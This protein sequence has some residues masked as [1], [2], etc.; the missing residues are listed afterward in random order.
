MS[1]E[2]MEN[3]LNALQKA[4]PFIDKAKELCQNFFTDMQSVDENVRR[5]FDEAQYQEGYS[6][7]K[8]ALSDSLKETIPAGAILE[9]N[10][11][12][13]IK[14][15][16]PRMYKDAEGVFYIHFDKRSTKKEVATNAVLWKKALLDGY[17]QS[18]EIVQISGNGN[19]Y[20]IK[21]GQLVR[22]I[23]IISKLN[24]EL[25]PEENNIGVEEE[26]LA[27]TTKA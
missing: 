21:I 19:G 6:E 26:E 11:F 14:L 20:Y 17:V 15:T 7:F 10:G 18:A 3:K 9:E 23:E 16:N 1:F 27:A 8:K 5:I 24:F 12:P 13:L 22:S 25:T 4:K 2:E